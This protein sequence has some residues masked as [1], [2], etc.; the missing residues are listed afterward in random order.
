MAQ[1]FPFTSH[2]LARHLLNQPDLPVYLDKEDCTGRL[3]AVTNARRFVPEG[4]TGEPLPV[5]LLTAAAPRAR[6][7]SITAG[8][9]YSTTP[10]ELPEGMPWGW[11]FCRNL[12]DDP[13]NTTLW[14]GC[15]LIVPTEG[16]Y[17]AQWFSALGQCRVLHSREWSP[18]AEWAGPIRFPLP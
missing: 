7:S 14:E 15:V 13:D 2:E 10:P 8:Y 1:R 17:L 9:S 5:L 11:F 6:D 3:H 18:G 16:G 4:D 12:G